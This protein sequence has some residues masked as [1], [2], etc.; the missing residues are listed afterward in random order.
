MATGFDALIDS[1]LSDIAL[2]GVHGAGSAEFYRFIQKFYE[3]LKDDVQSSYGTSTRPSLPAEGLGRK[4]YE[5]VWTWVSGHADMR[6][7]YQKEVRHY[8]LS[9]FEAAELHETGTCGGTSMTVSDQPACRP[10]NKSKRPTKALLSMGKA[11]R[12]YLVKEGKDDRAGAIVATLTPDRAPL[13]QPR[14]ALVSGYDAESVFDDPESTITAPRLYASQGRIW[15]ALTGHGIDL[16][17]VPSMEFVL[18]SLITARGSEG[19]AQTDLIRASGQDKR[20]VPHRTDELA[21]KGYIV[22]VPVQAGKVRTSLCV[23]NKFASQSHF[24]AS[25]AQEDVY[26]EDSF[27]LSGFVHLLYNTFKDAGVVP[28]RELRTRLGVPM[29]TW[30]KRATQGA[31]IRLDQTGMIK[32]LRVRKKKSEDSWLTCIQVL[33]KPCD[34]DVMNL[35]F[36]RQDHNAE[37]AADEVLDDDADGDTL[38]KDLEVDTLEDGDADVGPQANKLASTSDPDRIPPQWT[39]DQLLAN[40]AFDAVAIGGSDGWDSTQL[41]DRMVGPF[42]RRPL[43]SYFTRLTDDW[44]KTQPLNL[45]HLAIIRDSRNTAEKKYLHYVYRTHGNFQKA[46]DAGVVHWAGVSHSVTTVPVEDPS[47]QSSKPEG[48][49]VLDAWGF[50]ITNPKDLERSDGSATLSEAREAIVHPRTYG[51]RWDI[52]I[53]HEIGHQN[54]DE[55]P[56][57][58]PKFPR[59]PQRKGREMDGRPTL[60]SIKLMY[61]KK[62]APILSLSPAQRISLGLK[63]HG[64]LSKHAAKQIADHRR[65]TGDPCSLPDKI[66]G[67]PLRGGKPPLMSAEERI[68]A[69]LPPRG[70]LGIKQENAIRVQRGLAKIPTKT[71]TRE[72]VKSEPTVL[73]KQQRIDLKWIDH[74]RLPQDLIEG[75]RQERREG[76]ALKDSKVIALYDEVMKAAKIAKDM[77]EAAKAGRSHVTGPAVPSEMTDKQGTATVDKATGPAKHIHEERPNSPQVLQ[78]KTAASVPAAQRLDSLSTA[79]DE[80]AAPTQEAGKAAK[81]RSIVDTTTPTTSAAEGAMKSVVTAS[82]AKRKASISGTGPKTPKKRRTNSAI[83]PSTSAEESTTTGPGAAHALKASSCTVSPQQTTEEQSSLTI[84]SLPMADLVDNTIQTHR[85]SI[86]QENAQQPVH[87]Q[88]NTFVDVQDPATPSALKGKAIQGQHQPLDLVPLDTGTHGCETA[89]PAPSNPETASIVKKAS[90]YLTLVPPEID[91]LKISDKAKYRLYTERSLPGVYFD[92]LSK[93]KAPRGRPRK[94]FIATFRLPRLSNFDWF[95]PEPS[96]PQPPCERE[97]TPVQRDITFIQEASIGGNVE[98]SITRSGEV[99]FDAISN[100]TQQH[101]TNGHVPNGTTIRSSAVASYLGENSPSNLH[102]LGIDEQRKLRDDSVADGL[103]DQNGATLPALDRI[104]K[105][106]SD[107]AHT[108]R[109]VHVEQTVDRSPIAVAG[110]TLSLPPPPPR[111][112]AGWTVV[113]RSAPSGPS[114]YESP[115]GPSS[116]SNTA[117]QTQVINS[118]KVSATTSPVVNTTSLNNSNPA[119]YP[120][121]SLLR[122]TSSVMYK[123][124]SRA[125]RKRTK[126]PQTIGSALFFRRQIISDIIDMCNGVFPD[127]G[128]IGRPFSKLWDQRHG[129]A[130]GL[131]KPI[132]STVNETMRNMCTDPAFGLKRMIFQVRMNYKKGPFITK[133]SIIARTHLDASSPQVLKLARD[134]TNFSHERSQQYF[135]EEVRHLLD[136]TSLY[137]P[138]PRAPKDESIVLHPD[139]GELEDQIREAKKQRRQRLAEQRKSSAEARKAQNA[140]VEE[141]ATKKDAALAGGAPGK[142][143]RLASLNDKDKPYQPKPIAGVIDVVNEESDSTE[144]GRVATSVNSGDPAL[145]LTKPISRSTNGRNETDTDMDPLTTDEEESDEDLAGSPTVAAQKNLITEA[146]PDAELEEAS[147]KPVEQ[148][149]DA[150][151]TVAPLKSKKRVRIAEPESHTS[152]KRLRRTISSETPMSAESDTSPSSEVEEALDGDDQTQSKPK[153]KKNSK[154]GRRL[155]RSGPPPTLLERLT[156]LTGDP[157]DPIYI[158]PDRQRTRVGQSRPLSE[159]KKKQRSKKGSESK[160]AEDSDAL[161]RFK[162]LCCTLIIATL[163]SA[164]EGVADWSIVEMVYSNDK[165]FDMPKTKKMWAWIQTEMAPQITKLTENFQTL[166]LDAYEQGQLSPIEDPSTYDWKSLAQWATRSCAYPE[167][168]LPLLREALEK[169]AVDELEYTILD[170]AKWYKERVADR[171]RTLLQLQHSF[172]APLHRARKTTWSLEDKNLK[173]RSWIRANTAT[174]QA[175]YDGK[176]AHDKLMNLGQNALVSVVGDLVEKS[177]LRMRKLKRLL[178]GRNY[179]FT[180]A[181]A[182]KYVRPFELSDFMSAVRVKKEMDIAFTNDDPSKRFYSISQVEEDGPVAAIMTMVSAGI[183]K[184]I[185]QLPPVINEFGAPLPRLSIWGFC[186][187]DYIHRAMD[188]KRMFWDIYIV[189]TDKYLFGN[190]LQPSPQSHDSLEE[191]RVLDWQDLPEP[192]LPG[193]HDP[194]ALLPIWSSIDGQSITW[195]WWYRILNLVLQPLIFQPGATSSDIYLHCAAHTT[196]IFEIELVLSWLQSVKAVRESVGGGYIT[197]P[198]WWAVFGDNLKGV[199][200]DW[201]GEHVKR[202]SKNHE[203]QQWREQLNLQHATLHTESRQEAATETATPQAEHLQMPVDTSQQILDNPKK[204]YSISKDALETSGPRGQKEGS[205]SAAAVSQSA[206]PDQTEKSLVTER[207]VAKGQQSPPAT[208]TAA[209]DVE[210]VEVDAQGD[211][212]G[213]DAHGEDVDAEGEV[214]DAVY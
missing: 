150:G 18:L 85:E 163:M 3:P 82:P 15:Q 66:E 1:V 20:S 99:R 79:A 70:R 37:N 135:P 14:H 169:F 175:L 213:E 204:Q 81:S 183:V 40:L 212:D 130:K 59:G 42:W 134:I 176:H 138:V 90:K 113:N 172:A 185:P 32:R 6:I 139:P 162:K 47:S 146:G 45:R 9:E 168:P 26:R 152:R 71:E 29:T 100:A 155:D 205:T 157:N 198:G 63:P 36:R 106:G 154:S 5:N 170:R 191:A 192:P 122:R 120:S 208:D 19:I 209:E 89:R 43:E 38:M 31:L 186:E 56:R 123:P 107:S 153:A 101:V 58:S 164:E 53:S 125:H 148:G 17:K 68:A 93:Q 115:Y 171:T 8:T 131:E 51:P 96:T 132:S 76:I 197:Q 177:S 188:R 21:R 189:P 73:S 196:E 143:T 2:C 145:I 110:P 33:R 180:R 92:N 83:L 118:P 117:S 57:S 77:K 54:I 161:H 178:P 39:P 174:P 203:R 156:G 44:E 129:H 60:Q 160:S 78:D 91:K 69:G 207:P 182:R 181:F 103:R 22:K 23:H 55:I 195:P 61:E 86:A 187:G 167:L 211:E 142:R 128:E 112:V 62:F 137:W 50:K 105:V 141:V 67:G 16:K 184:L 35:R 121:T 25:S 136:D 206:V 84:L 114:G 109:Q 27:V 95:R 72:K 173:A 194:D 48:V 98:T 87:S 80:A 108:N 126:K 102:I 190:P 133:K 97:H 147:N 144:S 30:N 65:K 214:D 41:R 165:L 49:N 127:Q 12:E 52:A 11:I 166:F 4:F 158:P 199:G 140:R 64:R 74:G 13:R 159:R 200:D 104:T 10:D 88:V 116:H 124:R 24:L 210:M 94:A 7:I 28:T 149:P 75:L 119:S 46:V 151:F 201:F 179:S 202:K 111:T 193:K 34:E